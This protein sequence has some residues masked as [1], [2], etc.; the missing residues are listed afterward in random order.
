MHPLFAPEIAS[1]IVADRVRAA[2]ASRVGSPRRIRRSHL[3]RAAGSV[4]VGVGMRL[5]GGSSS[6]VHHPAR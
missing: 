3:R 4:L 6:S 2:N 5:A 1:E